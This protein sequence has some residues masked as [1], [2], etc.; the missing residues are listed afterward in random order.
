MNFEKQIHR[1]KDKL[2]QARKK[3]SDYLMFEAKAH[4]YF[5]SK[6]ATEVEVTMIEERYNI[7]LPSYFRAHYAENKNF[8]DW[9]KKWLDRII[10]W[11]ITF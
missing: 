2:F 4:N 6:P 10:V 1:I 11:E 3:D 8:L 7:L 9:H 5:L